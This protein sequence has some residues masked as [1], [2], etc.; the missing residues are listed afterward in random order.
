MRSPRSSR[1]SVPTNPVAIVEFL[2]RF[3]ATGFDV[4]QALV[5]MVGVPV[6]NTLGTFFDSA[7]QQAIGTATADAVNVLTGEVIPAWATGPSTP[8]IATFLGTVAANALVGENNPAAA[9]VAEAVS[10]AVVVLVNADG[11]GL[12]NLAAGTVV[13]FLGQ[14][15]VNTTVAA[16]AV[17]AILGALGAP[18]VPSL[19][20]PSTPPSAP[21][22]ATSSPASRATPRWCRVWAPPS[23]TRSPG[24]G[25]N[26]AIQALVEGKVD[27][28]VTSTLGDTPVAG[29][30]AAALAQ[31]DRRGAGQLGRGPGAAVGSRF[32]GQRFPGATRGRRR[33]VRNGRPARHRRRGRRQH[34]RRTAGGTA[35]ATGQLRRAQRCRAALDRPS[36]RC[37]PIPLCCNR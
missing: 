18:L 9:G 17:N 13:N 29:D 34:G 23:P 15:G 33:A 7:V 1:R 16:N 11:G 32:G 19:P 30:V 22:S 28:L 3:V 26:A 27:E 12:A 24:Y 14:P 25:R 4:K 5:D 10:D 21:Q 31:R 35:V 8:A 20:V 36:R 2:Y 6:Q 37:S